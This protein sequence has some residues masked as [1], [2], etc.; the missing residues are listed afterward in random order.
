MWEIQ[1]VNGNP[2]PDE[3]RAKVEIY[4]GR[5]QTGADSA[6][7]PSFEQS[8]F[9]ANFEFKDFKVLRTE[10]RGDFNIHGTKFFYNAVFYLK[11]NKYDVVI[12]PV[13]L[14]GQ[15][16]CPPREILTWLFITE[17]AL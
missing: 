16:T 17:N 3:L 9:C 14:V 10:V 5:K 12:L 13:P 6:S 4:Y 1:P 11:S 8:P 15:K 7:S 2:I